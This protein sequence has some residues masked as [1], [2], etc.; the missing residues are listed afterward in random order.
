MKNHISALFEK[1]E[2]HLRTTVELYKL[3]MIDKSADVVSS[4]TA[5][6]AVLV[7]VILFLISLNIGAAFW[8]GECMGKAY[9]GFFIVS[10]FYGLVSIVLFIFRN[11]WIKKPVKDLV[12]N[13][14]LN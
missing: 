13:K 2:I 4:L 6:L 11:R 10:G 12:I 14:S 8:I 7:F 1:T 9:L 5:N 3:K